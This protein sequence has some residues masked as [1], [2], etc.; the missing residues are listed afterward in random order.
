MNLYKRTAA[1]NAA[2]LDSKSPLP[3]KLR[4]L[5]ISVDGRTRQST[6]V[7]T[8]SSFGD[9]A[10]LLD[11]LQQQGYIELIQVDDRDV[12]AK[13][14]RVEWA[15]TDVPTTEHQGPSDTKPDPLA[16]AF[17]L[18]G[19]RASTAMSD[20]VSSWDRFQPEPRLLSTPSASSVGFATPVVRAGSP[21]SSAQYQLR[22]AVSL[23][24]DFVTT[25]MPADSLEIVLTLEGLSSVEQVIASLKG[26]QAMIA[27]SGS[28]ATRHL[29]ELRALLS[30]R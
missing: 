8:L 20:D 6:Y 10:A 24:S 2:A 22:S 21:P 14:G 29:E 25:H 15:A 11:S 18:A 5:L 13:S 30:R 16:S 1:G 7:T 27:P 12:P 4:T 23:M 17:E 19:I 3:R 9:V 28:A 26:Y